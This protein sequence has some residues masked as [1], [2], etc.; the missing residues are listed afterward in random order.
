MVCL[1]RHL[2]K[3]YGWRSSGHGGAA[4]RPGGQGVSQGGHRGDARATQPQQTEEERN[5]ELE[6]RHA[7][8][9]ARKKKK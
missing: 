9:E 8:L 5:A 1:S 7:K 2:K 6:E 4:A 3:I